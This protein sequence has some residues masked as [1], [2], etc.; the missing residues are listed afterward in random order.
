M[1]EN[2]DEMEFVAETKGWFNL[3]GKNTNVIH[4]VNKLTHIHVQV[5][6]NRFRKNTW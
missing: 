1:I 6:L 2:C 3:W 4:H 5:P